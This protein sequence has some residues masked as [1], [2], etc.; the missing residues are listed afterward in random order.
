MIGIKIIIGIVII[1][2]SG[3]IGIEMAE[4]LRAREDVLRDFSKFLNM[5]KSEMMYL[6]SNI[7]SFS[8]EENIKNLECLS[9]EDELFIISTLKNLGLSDINSQINI[10]DNAISIV[11]EKIKEAN[12]KKNK[13]S[14]VYKTVGIIAGI[15]VVVILI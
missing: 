2:I 5:L 15:I 1:C 6:N 4:N 3:Y 14:K 10:I 11:E 7:P 13:D 8:I 12:D 9:K